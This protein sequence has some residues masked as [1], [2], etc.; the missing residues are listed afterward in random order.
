MVT[1]DENV[2]LLAGVYRRGAE[3]FGRFTGF[4]DG[5]FGFAMTLLIS[6]VAVPAVQRSELRGA[7]GDDIPDIISYFVTFAVIG[8]YWIA[9][10]RLF[11][12][13]GFVTKK[14]MQ[15]NLL[16]MAMIAFM[17]FPTALFGRY[18]G[19]FIS[20]LL[21]VAALSMAS[22]VE[23][24]MIHEANSAGAMRVHMDDRVQRLVIVAAV[25]PVVVFGLS[26]VVAVF[27]VDWAPL[28]WLLIIPLEFS[29]GKRMPVGARYLG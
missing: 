1:E 25:I 13:L 10:H 26:L 23:A 3:E 20:L 15:M 29:V 8:H 21:Y 17:P 27:T 6:T 24:A 11:A 5:V 16:Y 12:A 18:N 14:I 7:L 28:T 9:H 2:D 4:S 22:L 19:E